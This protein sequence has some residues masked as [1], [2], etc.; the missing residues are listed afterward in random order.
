MTS[1]ERFEFYSVEI[2]IYNLQRELTK[3]AVRLH[4]LIIPNMKATALLYKH[5]VP[6]DIFKANLSTSCSLYNQ[7]LHVRKLAWLSRADN[8]FVVAM[9]THD[10]W[11]RRQRHE[12]REAEKPKARRQ[13]LVHRSPR[14]QWHFL[15]R[16]ERWVIIEWRQRP[17]QLSG[18]AT[19]H[20]AVWHVTLHDTTRQDTR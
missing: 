1:C 2:C 10:P 20:F 19:R 3:F 13:W 11:P 5:N 14:S 16:H 15:S 18:H 9:V 7:L 12:T 6:A 4:K 8:W 17:R